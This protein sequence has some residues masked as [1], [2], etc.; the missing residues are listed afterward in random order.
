MWLLVCVVLGLLAEFVGAW[1]FYRYWAHKLA[2][3]N[4]ID[5]VLW[6]NSHG[7][8][9]FVYRVPLLRMMHRALVARGRTLGF[10][11][12]PFVLS[13]HNSS[14]QHLL[15]G[16]LC[17]MWCSR[18]DVIRANRFLVQRAFLTLR[19]AP[20]SLPD[21]CA[22]HLRLGDVPFARNQHY[23]LPTQKWFQELTRLQ[24]WSEINSVVVICSVVHN[25]R[26][27]TQAL[28]RKYL[29]SYMDLIRK[30]F[31]NKNVALQ[32]GQTEQVDLSVFLGARLLASP[33]SSFSFYAG[34]AADENNVFFTG[35]CASPVR[36]NMICFQEGLLRHEDVA[37][38]SD[39]DA[40]FAKLRL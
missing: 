13:L 8:V 36:R 38:Y 24:V 29:A 11:D 18:P 19:V 25:T 5:S 12:V 20:V 28:A 2:L 31:P 7:L 40:V 39:T 6:L 37:E 32:Q 9:P 10:A 3:G 17:N 27:A 21:V 23:L 35:A 26:P 34:V 22:I 30:L 15:S 1:F 14:S 4:F 33:G 16:F